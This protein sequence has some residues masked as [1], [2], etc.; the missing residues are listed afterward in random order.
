M[1]NLTANPAF[2]DMVELDKEKES[3]ILGLPDMLI[4]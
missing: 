4:N 3:M 2:E 1:P